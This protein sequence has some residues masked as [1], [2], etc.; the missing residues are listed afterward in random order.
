MRLIK[1]GA[2]PF[3]IVIFLVTINGFSGESGTDDSSSL[4]YTDKLY[5]QELVKSDQITHD[6]EQKSENTATLHQVMAVV[7]VIWL[8]LA[9]FLFRLDRKVA[10]LEKQTKSIK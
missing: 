5:A 2:L 6:V 7:L 8:G 3:F 1:K 4:L 9:L 10:R